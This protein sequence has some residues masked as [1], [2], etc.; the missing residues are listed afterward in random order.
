M[1]ERSTQPPKMKEL[2]ALK[3]L[4]FLTVAFVDLFNAHSLMTV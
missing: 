4:S 2:V 3:Q 1:S